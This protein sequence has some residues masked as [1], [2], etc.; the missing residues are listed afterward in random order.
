MRNISTVLRAPE[1][2]LDVR[3]LFQTSAVAHSDTRL[4]LLWTDK[5]A[6]INKLN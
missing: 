1:R 5:Q 3:K 2:V 6:Q 4:A